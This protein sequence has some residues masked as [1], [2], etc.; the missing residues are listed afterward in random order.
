MATYVYKNAAG[1]VREI[2]A[3]MKRP[4]PDCVRFVD[5][6]APEDDRVM[7][8]EVGGRPRDLINPDHGLFF[9]VYGDFLINEQRVTGKFG[10]HSRTL[11]LNIPGEETNAR[12]QVL[13]KSKAHA[14]ELCRKTGFQQF[15]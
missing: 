15:D 1:D 9:R 4:P 13:V 8:V 12:G 2:T 11:P 6:P 5:N 10:Y 3:S 7:W 14:R